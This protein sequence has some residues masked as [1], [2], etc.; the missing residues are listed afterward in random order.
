[1]ADSPVLVVGPHVGGMSE[2][3]ET[4]FCVYDLQRLHNEHADGELA[5]LQLPPAPPGATRREVSHARRATK[6]RSE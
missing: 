5:E 2:L 4:G 3:V 1:M 6:L